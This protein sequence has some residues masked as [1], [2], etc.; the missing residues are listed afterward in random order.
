MK[1]LLLKIYNIRDVF[2]SRVILPLKV[3][4]IHKSRIIIS[5]LINLPYILHIQKL[6][7]F[8]SKCQAHVLA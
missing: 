1:E 8:P 5:A 2:G 6:S 4:Q 3:S 7:F